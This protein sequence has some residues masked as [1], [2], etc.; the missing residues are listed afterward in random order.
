MPENP[1]LE[2]VNETFPERPDFTFLNDRNVE[3]VLKNRINGTS[4]PKKLLGIFT[5]LIM[6][7]LAAFGAYKYLIAEQDNSCLTMTVSKATITNSVEATGTLEPVRK[8]EMG[9]KNDGN[10]VSIN[11]NPGDKVVKGQILAEQD[12]NSLK[13]ALEQAENTA[14]Q[15]EINLQSSILSYETKQRTFAQQKKL[16]EAG[17]LAQTDMDTAKDDLRK[18]ELDVAAARAKL[19]A[20]Q[21]KLQQARADLT[22]ATLIAP[23]DG[24]IGA[25]NGQVGQINGIN[26]STSTLLTVM[27]EELQLNALVNEADIGRI[28]IG[29]EV[30]F[31]SSAY[32]GQT[33][34]G[35][36]ERITPEASTVNN[37]QYYPVRISCKDPQ[38]RLHSGMTVTAQI[39]LARKTNVL[40]VPMMA[41]TY[42]QTYL[43]SQAANTK[44]QPGFAS[45]SS[46]KSWTKRSAARQPV[47]SGQNI[48]PA[49]VLVLKNQKPEA[50]FVVLGISDNSNY[51]VIKGLSEGDK[52][53]VGVSQSSN[54][55][56]S[57]SSNNTKSNSRTRNNNN[58]PGGGM[59]GPPPGF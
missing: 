21:S 28:K 30:E 12:A 40:T 9:F 15:D 32:P 37:V 10:I 56:S 58:G 19:A 43:K 49:K 34:Q 47:S 52:V 3:A 14:A 57:A 45:S 23:F 1:N 48:R 26:S 44:T 27:S 4:R 8:S 42:A 17:A 38:Q 59:G 36:V 24:I 2:A 50:V 18:S 39:I 5:V 20:D 55:S 31:T 46:Q 54:T 22:E 6:L 51:E 29:Q 33:F 41:V 16:L 25:V 7:G 35:Q 13:T 11:V 53:V